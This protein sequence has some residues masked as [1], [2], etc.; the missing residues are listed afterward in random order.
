MTLLSSGGDATSSASE[1]STPSSPGTLPRRS[2]T[3]SLDKSSVQEMLRRNST[4]RKSQQDQM[5][6][7]GGRLDSI[8]T[9]LIELRRD[10]SLIENSLTKLTDALVVQ[11]ALE[12]ADNA[13]FQMIPLHNRDEDRIVTGGACLCCATCWAQTVDYFC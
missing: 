4:E 7:M 12:A 11:P 5:K 1:A 10:Q 9:I 6:K 8:E 13:G 2:S 3:A